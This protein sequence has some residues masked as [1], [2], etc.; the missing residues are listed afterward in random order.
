M[1]LILL[2]IQMPVMKSLKKESPFIIII[3]CIVDGG[4]SAM[5]VSEIYVGQ[6]K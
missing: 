5:K 3:K 4:N 2:P 1:I 6:G